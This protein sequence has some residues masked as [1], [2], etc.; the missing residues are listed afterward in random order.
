MD[1]DGQGV[2]TPTAVAMSRVITP[3]I[4]LQHKKKALAN[5]RA[6]VHVGRV[7]ATT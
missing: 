3:A 1:R 4:L 2:V 7:W 5:A 6:H